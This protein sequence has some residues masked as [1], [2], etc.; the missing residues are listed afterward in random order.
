MAFAN[1][2]RMSISRRQS[3]M[4]AVSKRCLRSDVRSRYTFLLIKFSHPSSTL[5]HFC[6]ARCPKR[7]ERSTKGRDTRE[8]RKKNEG[9]RTECWGR[10]EGRGNT[11][12]IT[13]CVAVSLRLVS[14]PHFFPNSFSRA[15]ILHYMRIS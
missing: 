7:G 12:W 13:G 9:W 14:V 4:S 10:K 11:G 8:A 6:R 1:I 5:L 3:K 15:Q 2:S